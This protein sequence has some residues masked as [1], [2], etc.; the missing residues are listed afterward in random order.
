MIKE[1][2]NEH[3]NTLSGSV[4][5]YS[6]RHE[7]YTN[8]QQKK[9]KARKSWLLLV[10][11]SFTCIVMLNIF[12]IIIVILLLSDTRLVS[13]CCC[14]CTDKDVDDVFAWD[15]NGV[16]TTKFSLT[17]GTRLEHTELRRDTDYNQWKRWVFDRKVLLKMKV[18][19]QATVLHSNR[20]V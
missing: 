3:H 14:C 17:F 11:P 13:C 9:H 5:V 1:Q 10:P 4:V 2:I 7:L 12:T 15:L 16:I 6:Y 19:E 20:W 18:L 8:K